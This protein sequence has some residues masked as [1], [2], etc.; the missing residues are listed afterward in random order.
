MILGRTLC[1]PFSVYTKKAL[2][3]MYEQN[4]FYKKSPRNSLDT[5]I[6]T[7]A[8]FIEENPFLR[9]VS[10]DIKYKLLYKYRGYI[11]DFLVT[12]R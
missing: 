6:E 7:F 5:H 2:S 9:K 8:L 3:I 4:L 11:G 10:P 1:V 12:V